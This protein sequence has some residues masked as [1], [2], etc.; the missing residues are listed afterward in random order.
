MKNII[1]LSF[2][3][4]FAFEGYSQ[5]DEFY[6]NFEHYFEQSDII[7]NPTIQ[8]P[9]IAAFQKV[10]FIPV[11]NYTGRVDVTIPI[12]TIKSG[13][14]TIPI[15]ISYNSGGV[16]VNDR[17]STVGLNWS[18]NAGGAI[19]KIVKGMEDFSIWDDVYQSDV[20]EWE[21]SPV[22]WL[23]PKYSAF[24]THW[25]VLNSRN[26]GF[27]RYND[28]LPD[29][30]IVSAPGLNTKYVHEKSTRY[31]VGGLPFELTGQG[32]I[33]TETFGN[34]VVGY[35]DVFQNVPNSNDYE[36]YDGNYNANKTLSCFEKIDITS[37]SGLTYSFHDFDVSQYSHFTARA[38]NATSITSLNNQ[39]KSER[40]VESYR[41]SSVSDPKTN[42]IVQF[43]YQKYNLDFY[44]NVHNETY[45][46]GDYEGAHDTESYS[47]KYPQL[48]RLTKITFDGGSVEFNY[49][50][51]RLDIVGEVALTQ[52]VIKDSKGQIIKIF[53][54]EYGYFQTSYSTS[55]PQSKR[56]R[57]E[58]VYTSSSDG[59]ELPAYEMTYNTN[60]LPL[61]GSWGQD[62][63]GYNNGTY[64]SPIFP[65]KPN[66]YFYPDKGIYSSL[67]FNNGSGYHLISGNYSLESNLTNSKSAILEKIKYP[68]GGYSEFE[69]ELN[70]FIIDGNEISGGGLRI[71]SQ[72][73]VDE[74]LK[75]QI[76][77]YEYL[78][79]T[80]IS[81]GSIVALPKYTELYIK[82][83]QSSYPSS[84]SASQTLTY[85]GFKIYLVSKAQA[86]LTNNSFVG[87]SRVKVK[88]RIENGYSIYDYTSPD[89]FPMQLATQTAYDYPSSEQYKIDM[90]NL[91]ISNGKY[92][93]SIDRDVY[94]GKLKESKVYDINDNLLIKKEN[95]YTYK[96]FSD[97][98]L[99]YE[100]KLCPDPM[101]CY[102]S[103]GDYVEN[104]IMETAEL[105][106]E[107]Y[108]LTSTSKTEYL[109]NGNLV[110]TS[111]NIYDTN[112][113]F[114]VKNSFTDSNDKSYESNFVFA[115]NP[116]INTHPYISELRAQNRLSELIQKD[117]I[118]DTSKIV[119]QEEFQYNNFGNSI[120][121]IS[122]VKRSKGSETLNEKSIID[123][124]DEYGN[125]TQFHHKNGSSTVLIWGYNNQKLIAKI[126][127]AKYTDIPPVTLYSLQSL[128]NADD[129]N[130]ME[131]ANCNEDYLRNALANLRSIIALDNSLITYHTYDPLIGLTSTT[132]PSGYTSY[133]K[134]DNFNRLQ[135]IKNKDGDVLK[136]YKYHYQGEYEVA[137][138][139]IYSVSSTDNGN[140]SVIHESIVNEGD[141]IF[142]TITPN[143]GYEITSINVNDISQSISSFFIINNVLNNIIIDVEFTLVSNFIV[144][145]TIDGGNNGSV[146]ISPTTVTSGGSSTITLTPDSGYE[147]E[148]VKVGTTSYPVSNNTTTITNITS[149]TDVHVKFRTLSLVATP[150]ALSYSWVDWNK[151]V[152]VTAVGSWTV[153]KSDSWITISTTSGSGNDTF[154]VRPLKNLGS[155]RTGSV[156]VSN[157]TTTITISVQ[158]YG[159][160]VPE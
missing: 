7:E 158:Q 2:I 71:K 56:L 100:I 153:T 129:D 16:K 44:D 5:G 23:Y 57:L 147:V 101:D 55:L 26:A 110:E 90:A 66:I 73:I 25:S 53:N 80:G 72:K 11:N 9:D 149:N 84:I 19:S 20:N 98:D 76:L 8:P 31:N 88:D 152:T 131:G 99:T 111:N 65:A 34:P 127:N 61:R 107:R 133:Y 51:Q 121:D 116:S 154:T 141:D 122:N 142:V 74:N 78:T 119:L 118:Y 148:Y 126:E 155:Y 132:D 77:D 83:N 6:G 33:I 12:Y 24:G 28:H 96:K 124:R 32:N 130:C 160:E 41:L 103:Y 81:S 45:T 93:I 18:L 82:N 13:N 75:E 17:G 89:E 150:S 39:W 115:N 139:T 22:G 47:I 136:S 137:A 91:A 60:E 113:P 3:F 21:V 68:V 140:G 30:F 10:N 1:S 42:R 104:S 92:S 151:T 97:I 156:A 67:P 14:I 145:Y 29:L 37:T 63:L 43:E 159:D 4:L 15:S 128:S 48:N 109:P 143:S 58:K 59:S 125:I 70:K 102:S 146:N 49:A 27:G 106:S 64:A 157:G 138:P 134:Y 86:E 112:L 50:L 79:T 123:V 46:Y 54:L 95:Q 85:F 135:Y 35:Y 36:Y 120:I 38:D 69:Y 52:I 117:I 87:Y 108:L 62:F 114:L 144:S 94:R 105:P 40:K